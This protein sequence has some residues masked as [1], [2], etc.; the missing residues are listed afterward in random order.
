MNSYIRRI[1][2][3]VLSLGFDPRSTLRSF[4]NV[5]SYIIDL[6]RWRYLV[7]T[8]ERTLFS[9]K[10]S[11]ALSDKGSSSANTPR[12]Y[13]QQDLWA[14]KHIYRAAPTRH[15]DVGSRLDGFVAHLLTFRTVEVIDIRPLAKHVDGLQFL[16]ADMMSEECP[17][18]A[19]GPSVSCLHALEHFGLGRYGD[20]VMP[21]GWRRGLRNLAVLVEPKGRLYLSVPVGR[22]AIEFNAHRI[23]HPQYIIDE[24]ASHGLTLREFAHI[25]EDGYLHDMGSELGDTIQRVSTLEYACGLFIFEKDLAR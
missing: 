22:A 6:W 12:H 18:I 2:S 3:L 4:F 16:Q 24:A 5:P 1:G 10:I 11:P 19:P 25:D 7:S 14:A 15:V 8:N 9:F 13:F 23:F 20:P 17:A 21:D